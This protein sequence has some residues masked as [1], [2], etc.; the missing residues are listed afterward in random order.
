MKKI[1]TSLFIAGVVASPLALFAADATTTIPVVTNTTTSKVSPQEKAL[2]KKLGQLKRNS[3]DTK[4][5]IKTN[6]S[7]TKT[8]INKVKKERAK[9]KKTRAKKGIHTATSTTAT[10][11]SR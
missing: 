5:K 8:Q 3:K 10:T 9:V 11:T 2:A 1:I 4:Q 6:I 7:Q